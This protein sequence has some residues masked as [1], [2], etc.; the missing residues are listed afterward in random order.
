MMNEKN[1]RGKKQNEMLKRYIT[2]DRRRNAERS[3]EGE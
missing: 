2:N 1:L 3:A